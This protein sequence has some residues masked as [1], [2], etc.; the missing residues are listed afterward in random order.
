M[1]KT[2]IFALSLLLLTMT[3]CTSSSEQKTPAETT[4]PAVEAGDSTAAPID[5]KETSITLNTPL[6]LASKDIGLFDYIDVVMKS[7]TYEY[8][9]MHCQDRYQGEFYLQHYKD[10]K[11]VNETKLEPFL[12]D[13]IMFNDT[14]TLY[15]KDYNGDGNVDFL[16][17]ENI[18]DKGTYYRMFTLTEK[19][20]FEQLDVGTE[21]NYLYIYD[22]ELSCKLEKKGKNTWKYKQYDMEKGVS[23]ITIQWNGSAFEEIE[24]KV[25][26][27]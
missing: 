9:H 21:G 3:A 12:D 2:K 13:E 19:N 27:E 23:E 6:V 25:V 15:T 20:T 7:G 22:G 5:S 24:R 8:D 14:F 1:K 16:I 11:L 26:T 17:G 18:N 4:V 10:E